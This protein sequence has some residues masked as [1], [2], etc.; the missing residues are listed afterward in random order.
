MST[1]S[2]YAQP[3][4]PADARG[5]VDLSTLGTGAAAAAPGPS[6]EPQAGPVLGAWSLDLDE[7][8]F[9]DLV[10][11]SGRVPV[12]IAVTN[13]RVPGADALRASLVAA[14]DAEQGRVV[15][16]LA[17]PDAQPRIAQALQVQQLPTVFAVLGG[18]PMPLFS[19]PVDD[20]QIKGLLQELLQVAIQQGMAGTVPPFSHPEG[21][22]APPSRF[23]E[24]EAL[25]AQGDYAQAQALYEEALKQNPGDDDAA[26][27]LHRA[28]LLERVAGMDAQAVRAAAAAAPESV[29][30]QL[31][32]ADLDVVGGHVED[33]FL[34]LVRFIAAHFDEDRE[35]ARAHLVEL[36]G[37]VGAQDPR[38][39]SARGRL[40]A[41][42]F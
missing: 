9:Q 3:A 4:Q 31:D 35:A 32:V 26:V 27:G 33:A 18:R 42:L 36:F 10:Q 23:A 22:T 29:Q 28:R 8:T 20:T 24:A 34:R 16:G 1:P 25:V 12:I 38:V 11:L 6:G 37:V 19:G 30:A 40:A 5:A 13:E 17:D 14:V 15:L 2:E 41:A 21:T 7:Q 39:V